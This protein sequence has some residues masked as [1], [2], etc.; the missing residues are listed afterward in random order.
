MVAPRLWHYNT[1][2]GRMF[3]AP[4][5]HFVGWKTVPATPCYFAWGCFRYFGQEWAPRRPWGLG[6]HRPF[7][8]RVLGDRHER[9][10]GRRTRDAMAA[11]AQCRRSLS[12]LFHRPHSHGG[13]PARHQ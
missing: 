5:M 4:A 6:R 9:D 1:E 2:G 13:D 12:R 3:T 10:D 11:M 8:N 7:G